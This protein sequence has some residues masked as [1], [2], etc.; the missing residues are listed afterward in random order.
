VCALFGPSELGMKFTNA[1]GLPDPIARAVM[2]DQYNPGQ[3]DFTVTTLIGP[4]RIRVLRKRNRDKLTEDVAD[5]LYSLLGQSVHTILERAAVEGALAE[6][7]LYANV[8]G[9]RI[10]GQLDHAVFLP[11]YGLLQDYKLCSL[12][13]DTKKPEWIQQI[14]MLAWLLRA[15]GYDVT[16]GQ[17][18]PIYR[19]WSKA[20]ARREPG[21]PQHQSQLVDIELWPD[22]DVLKFVRER[23]K[24]HVDAEMGELPNCTDEE[25]W[26]RGEQFAVMKGDNKRATKLFDFRNHAEE[27]AKTDPKFR[28]ERRAG[29][30]VRCR[31]YCQVS[32]HCEQ[33]KRLSREPV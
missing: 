22:E 3:S 15:N 2:N 11:G 14:N 12:W 1:L 13:T 16:K 7:R 19:D 21:Y 26:Y 32:D 23:I 6:V 33:Y 8:D 25:R 9:L 24:A 30:N 4:P 5:R 10:S 17:I 20:R 27:F 18:V 28:V 29:E 31:D